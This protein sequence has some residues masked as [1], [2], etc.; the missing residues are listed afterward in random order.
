MTVIQ[1]YSN[2]DEKRV[3]KSP[4]ET[5]GQHLEMYLLT[6][7]K[8]DKTKMELPL[9]KV[10][11]SASCCRTMFKTTYNSIWSNTDR[12]Q[13]NYFNEVG[14]TNTKFSYLSYEVQRKM[15]ST[16]LRESDS[17]RL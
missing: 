13:R 12:K 14:A 1:F 5:C 3:G 9:D 7:K 15:V 8:Q 10:S 17:V 16:K 11:V 4:Q 2:I 6:L